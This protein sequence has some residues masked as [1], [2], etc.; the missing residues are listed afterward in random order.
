[1]LAVATCCVVAPSASA[2]PKPRPLFWGAQVGKQI[3][4]T[5][6]PWD[7]SALEKFEA[8][9]HKGLSLLSFYA[10]FANCTVS[11]CEFYGFPT[12][13][14]QNIRQHGAIPFL[15]WSSASIDN[16]PV[17]QP[18][19]R[20]ARIIDG[21]Y[22]EYI[23][24]FAKAARDW[25]HPFFLRFDWE[26]N[27]FW[28]PW[29]EVLNG[30][31]PGEFVAAWR[32]V[33]DIFTSVGAT[34]A[35]WVWCPNI[36]LIPKLKHFRSLYPG[37]AYVDWTCLDGFNWGDTPNSAGWMSFNEIF[38]ST[39]REVV[40]IAPHKP[41]VIGETGSDDRGGSKAAWIHN[42]L[43]VVPSRFRKVRGLIWFDESTQGM[44][45]PIESSKAATRSFARGIKRRIYRPNIYGGL[46][47][48]P[49]RPPSWALPRQ[50]RARPI[51]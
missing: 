26:M 9:V 13:P 27:G 29:N 1:L 34:N 44:H 38:R 5:Q 14:M 20:L 40:K 37:N 6:A 33:H 48:G 50:N 39:Y 16:D 30:N 45:W 28:F 24:S 51:P 12:A 25:G 3:T 42:T 15:S 4:G 32:H 31:K 19:F 7:M 46:A 2:K 23:R 43:R 18:D 36:A 17:L 11:P 35:T 10:P 41:M 8:T 49:I 22:D 47:T 21:S